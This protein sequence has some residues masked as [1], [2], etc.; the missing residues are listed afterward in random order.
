MRVFFLLYFV[1]VFFYLVIF[2]CCAKF[3]A[4]VL[5]VFSPVSS[6]FSSSSILFF[7]SSFGFLFIVLPGS[8]LFS[9]YFLPFFLS[10]YARYAFSFSFPCSRLP[11][12]FLFIFHPQY[13]LLP[14]RSMP[15]QPVGLFYWY[16]IVSL[17]SPLFSFL[18]YWYR[19]VSIVSPFSYP[20]SYPLFL[21]FL[22]FS[23]CVPFFT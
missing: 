6:C 17:Y 11:A 12:I 8:I 23:R 5:F 19:I 13:I 10:R 3:W 20:F 7:S 1:S 14:F 9:L 15:F 18:F 16:R 2:S 22:S 21:I 4:Y